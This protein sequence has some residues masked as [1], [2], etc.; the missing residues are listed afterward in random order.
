MGSDLIQNRKKI[1][2]A[3]EQE[4]PQRK[5]RFEPMETEASI[6]Q[7]G[8]I[9]MNTKMKNQEAHSKCPQEQSHLYESIN[10]AILRNQ[11]KPY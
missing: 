8:K 1:D 5:D 11:Q 4:L 3:Q 9:Q 2:P 10:T 6:C 7:T